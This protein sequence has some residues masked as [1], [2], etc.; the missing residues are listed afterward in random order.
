VAEKTSALKLAAAWIEDDVL[1]QKAK[2]KNTSLKA[3][4]NE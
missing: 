4:G 1:R 3:I 2:V